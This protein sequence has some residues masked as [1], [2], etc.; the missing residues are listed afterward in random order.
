[1]TAN[2]LKK[3][4]RIRKRLLNFLLNYF[5]PT[6]KFIV[7]LSQN[8]DM[9]VTKRQRL[10]YIRHKNKHT[11]RYLKLNSKFQKTNNYRN[12]A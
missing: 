12:I 1:M 4:I 9:L 2:A 6:N 3:H 8:L 10:I 7:S 5:S 11:D